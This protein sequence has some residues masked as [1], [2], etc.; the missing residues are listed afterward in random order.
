[1]SFFAGRQNQKARKVIEINK[2]GKIVIVAVLI[3]A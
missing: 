1:L 2:A 3:A